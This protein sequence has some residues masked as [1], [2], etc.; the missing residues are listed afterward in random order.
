[1][2]IS[3]TCIRCLLDRQEERIRQME[4][5]DVKSAYLKEV[6]G[7]IASSGED[8]TAPY[9]VYGINRVYR[10][11]FGSLPDY[12]KEKKEFNALML[13]LES[14][15]ET[16]LRMGTDREEVLRYALYYART[17]NYIDYGATNHVEK[18]TLLGLLREAKGEALDAAVLKSL[19]N[20]LETAGKLAYLA[21]NC[22]E[23]VADKLL[24]KILKEQYPQLE[25]TVIVRGMPVLND[26]VPGDAEDVG[27][28]DMVK[29]IG[30]GNGVA[31]T[32]WN[33]LSEEAEH[34]LSG[35]DVI[36]SKGQGNFETIH[37]CGLNIYYLFLCKCEWFTKRFGMERLK[38][39]F[40]NERD[41]AG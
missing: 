19:R 13:G 22:G 12:E 16:D 25:I 35:A 29:V 23:I 3:A 31:G 4:D 27:L 37:G 18:E 17:A 10:R 40:V 5:E 34:A 1:M 26:A 9:L 21:D 41:I 7:I 32:Q 11:Y 30:N 8:A 39:V 2:K 6:A 33:L 20:E 15:L 24:I 38:G 14:E 36:L 28:T